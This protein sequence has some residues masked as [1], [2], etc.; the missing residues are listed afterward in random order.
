[1]NLR[2]LWA[3]ATLCLVL[4]LPISILSSLAF[5]DPP[6]LLPLLSLLLLASQLLLKLS[7]FEQASHLLG[8]SSDAP[9]RACSRVRTHNPLAARARARTGVRATSKVI[10]TGALPR[11]LGRLYSSTAA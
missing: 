9:C 11:W 3:I 2:K 10:P 5:A 7:V 4:A 8:V 6:S 1:M